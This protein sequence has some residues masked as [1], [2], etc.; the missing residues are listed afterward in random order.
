M[1]SSYRQWMNTVAVSPVLSRADRV[2]IS[3]TVGQAPPQATVIPCDLR[4]TGTLSGQSITL[5]SGARALR[6]TDELLGR[7]T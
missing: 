1:G 5:T 7:L 2:I 4:Y 3:K 6:M